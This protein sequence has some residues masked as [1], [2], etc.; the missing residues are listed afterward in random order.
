MSSCRAPE[1]ADA[2]FGSL[3]KHSDVWGF[4]ACVLHMASGQLPY[5]DLNPIQ[6]VTAMLKKR[7]P[8]V[9]TSLPDWLQQALKQCLS[10]DTAARPSVAELYTVPTAL[11]CTGQGNGKAFGHKSI[12]GPQ[13][14]VTLHDHIVNYILNKYSNAPAMTDPPFHAWLPRLY[15]KYFQARPTGLQTRA[16]PQSSFGD[17]TSPWRSYNLPGRHILTLHAC[18]SVGTWLCWT[19]WFDYC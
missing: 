3:G 14:L 18:S 10:F 19:A 1:Q 2:D 11:L 8:S 4:A 5:A 15:M 12:C 9:P 7:P 17:W 16:Y 13:E 6:M